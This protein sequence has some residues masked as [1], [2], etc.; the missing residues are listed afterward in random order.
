MGGDEKGRRVERG[1]V[2]RLEVERTPL[3]GSLSA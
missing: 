2:I 1:D 3:E